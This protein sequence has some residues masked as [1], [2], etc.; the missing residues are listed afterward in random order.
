MVDMV[1]EVLGGTT[2]EVVVGFKRGPEIIGLGDSLILKDPREG[3]LSLESSRVDTLHH[4]VVLPGVDP[5]VLHH[6]DRGTH[7]VHGVGH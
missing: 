4:V 6:V 7:V 1:F 5:H 3:I 2:R